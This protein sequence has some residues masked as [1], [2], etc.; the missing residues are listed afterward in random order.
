MH[1][2][3]YTKDNTTILTGTQ[4]HTETILRIMLIE[5]IIIVTEDIIRQILPI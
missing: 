4:I 2:L 5:T 1:K 3:M